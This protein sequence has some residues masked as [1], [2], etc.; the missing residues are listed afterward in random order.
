MQE[1]KL[2]QKSDVFMWQA[3]KYIENIQEKV[4]NCTENLSISTRQLEQNAGLKRGAIQNILEGKSNNPK[5]EILVAIAEAVG[6]TID[7]LIGKSESNSVSAKNYKTEDHKAQN[8]NWNSELY[9]NCVMEVE[10]YL[11]AKNLSPSNE[12]IL[13]FIKEAYTYSIQG[14]DNKA[15]SKFIKWFIDNYKIG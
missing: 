11:K 12:Q 15:D 8:L 3:K 2:Q 13:L 7:Q 10:N 6:C 1:K 9:Q 14:N 4:Q 5:I